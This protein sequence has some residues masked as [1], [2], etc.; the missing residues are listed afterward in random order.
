M[1]CRLKP[2]LS[3]GVVIGLVS[4]VSSVEGRRV[5][6]GPFTWVPQPA[7][8]V[9]WNNRPKLTPPSWK[10]TRNH[11]YQIGE[12]THWFNQ[13]FDQRISGGLRTLGLGFMY[14]ILPDFSTGELWTF[15]W[16]VFYRSLTQFVI[17][18]VSSFW[19]WLKLYRSLTQFV[20]EEV[21]SFW[22]WLKPGCS[23]LF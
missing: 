20:I 1:K 21:S 5:V 7:V 3:G 13:L 9:A 15:G 22:V 8:G 6:G 2:S 11:P 17:E 14:L 19:V 18:E 4:R 12:I 16:V 23:P 10:L